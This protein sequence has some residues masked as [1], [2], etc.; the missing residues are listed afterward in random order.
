MLEGDQQIENILNNFNY[1]IKKSLK[2]TSYQDREDLE[3]EIKAKIIEKIN[4]IE[5]KKPPS[6]WNVVDY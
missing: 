5:L 3:Q 4:T 6:F 1:K 2:N